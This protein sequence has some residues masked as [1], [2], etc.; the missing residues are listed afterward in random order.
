[1]AGF[2]A[3]CQNVRA[4]A[5]GSFQARN[6]VSA[7]ILTVSGGNIN[8]IRRLNDSTPQGPPA[9]YTY[10]VSDDAGN[11]Y[12]GSSGTLSPIATGMTPNP[13]AMVTFRPNASVQPWMYVADS[14]ADGNVTIHTKYAIDSTSTTFPCSGMVKVRSDGLIYKIGV[15]E[16]QDAPTVSTASSTTTGSLTING[17]QEPYTNVGGL[18]TNWPFGATQLQSAMTSIPVQQGQTVTI[19]GV[20]GTVVVGGVTHHF[21]DLITNTVNLNPGW[22]VFPSTGAATSPLLMCA[23]T[24]GAGS[25]QSPSASPSEGEIFGIGSIGLALTVPEGATQLQFGINTPDATIGTNTGSFDVSYK[26]TT[27]N[28]ATALSILGQ[29][30]INYFGDSPSSGPVGE[31]IWKNPNDLGSGPTRAASTAA[32]STTGNSFI[33]DA[34]ITAGQP[35]LP[36]IDITNSTNP[37]QAAMQWSQLDENGNITGTIPVFSP[38]IKGVDGNT[39]FQNFNFCVTGFLFVPQ[40]GNYTLVLT[41]KDNCILGIGGGASFVSGTGNWFGSNE[42][43]IDHTRALTLADIS[44]FGQTESVISGLPLMPVAPLQAPGG[45]FYNEGGQCTQSVLTI[46]FAAT[47]VVPIEID[48]DYWFHSGRILLLQG[49]PVPGGAPAI[50]P[51]ITA[52]ATID[53]SYVYVWR[54][55]LTG[56]KSNPSPASAPITTPST[57]SVVG[58]DWSPDPQI[59]KVDYF[60]QD[61]ELANLTLIG[62]GPND[63]GGG[64]G[65]NTPIEDNLLSSSAANNPTVEFDNFEPFPSIDTPKSGVVSVTGG[66]VTRVSGDPFNVRWLPGTV[67]EIGLPAQNPAPPQLAYTLISRPTNANTIVL[68][69]VQA[70]DNLIYNIPEPILAAQPLPYTFGP[71]DNINFELAVGDPLRPGTYYW[72]KGSNLDAA[73]DTNQADLT[74]PGEPLVNGAMT[75]GLAMIGSISRQWIIE[76]NFFN[77]LAT[78]IGTVGNT[79]SSQATEIPRGIYMPRCVAVEGGGKVFTRVQDG[80]LVSV[81]G[82]GPRSITDETLYPIFPHE[83]STPVAVVRNGVTVFPPDDTLPQLQQFNTESQWLY[84]DYQGTDGNLHTLVFDIEAMAWLFDEYSELAAGARTHSA[85]AGYGVQG[86][87]IGSGAT[88]RQFTSAAGGSGMMNLATGA[89][90]GV[91]YQHARGITLEYQLSGSATVYFAVADEGNGSYAPASITLNATGGALTKMWYPVSP[92]KWKLLQ[93]GFTSGLNDGLVVNLDG[94][95]LTV[96]DWGSSEPYKP[97]QPFAPSGGLGSEG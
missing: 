1:M 42:S 35:V 28:V 89:V 5:R 90:G 8:T 93:V 95:A 7:P 66:V 25:I 14:S 38:A 88:A 56:A 18:N 58:S 11:L 77:A 97:L 91:G 76:P 68:P 85:K 70:G 36:G 65:Q 53:R 73:P 71:T 2:V 59:D 45:S 16:P 43:H 81:V 75:G 74:D 39:A 47:G 50:I 55:S 63:Q 83:G 4:Y 31:Y 62:T 44:S 49:S 86:V 22:W 94:T 15:K 82:A 26:I 54:S 92:N 23:F 57:G 41:N 27:S 20:T 9:G 46:H 84:W 10:I 33:F 37:T 61:S 69:G 67:I 72:C 30:T 19:E 32:G 48:Y 21:S 6:Y 24:D 52:T 80:I 79:F 34:T 29:L 51:P 12:C 40:P 87:L 60:R 13:K 17:T 3:V 64:T 96:R 78:A